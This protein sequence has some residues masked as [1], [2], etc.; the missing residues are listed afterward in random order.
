[1]RTLAAL[2]DAGDGEVASA[3][4]RVRE[5]RVEQTFRRRVQRT[6]AVLDDETGEAEAIWFGR[7]FIERRLSEG[8]RVVISGRVKHRGWSI[9]FDNPEF[10]RDDG[11]ALLHAGRIVPVYRL[12]AG[13]TA[14]RL[15]V[16]IRNRS[17]AAF[18]SN[19]STIFPT[20][21]DSLEHPKISGNPR[22]SGNN[23]FSFIKT[24]R[25][26]TRKACSEAKGSTICFSLVIQASGFR[27]II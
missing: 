13:L 15:R 18:A 8:D 26:S 11:S 4:V 23:C 9:V 10:Q 27:S 7:R 12:T 19:D 5:L 24:P 20:S 22:Y 14:A 6:M 25:P 17:R 1:M 16:L 3:R 2:R 21:S